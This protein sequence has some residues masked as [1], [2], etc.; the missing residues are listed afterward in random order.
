MTDNADL[1]NDHLNMSLGYKGLSARFIYDNYK[2]TNRDADLNA[3]SRSYQLDFLSAMS[4]IKYVHIWNKKLQTVFRLAHKYSEP[5][6]FKGQP[7]PADSAY[8]TYTLH[9]NTIRAN[10]GLLW[11]PFR[12]LNV[13]CGMEGYNDRG[14][15]TGDNVFRTDS[16]N[17]VSYMNYAPYAQ[18][19]FKSLF[20][21][22]TVGARY[23]I[24]TAF[25]SA[26]NPRLGITKQVGVFNFKLLYASSFRAPAIESIQYGV[27]KMKLKPERSNTLEFEASVKIRKDMYLSVNAFDINTRNAIRYFVN[28]DTVV[29][30]FPDGYRNSDKMIGS[31]GLELEYK[32]KSSFGSVNVAYSFYTVANK[33]VDESN[34]VPGNTNVT[35]GTAQN[36]CSISGTINITGKIYLSPAVIFLD[37]RYGYSSV[38]AAGQGILTSYVPQT[39]I[40]LFAGSTDLI[41]N[42]ALGIGVRNLTDEK[43]IYPQAYN[44][45]HAPLPGMGRE[46]YIR[47]NYR[48]KFKQKEN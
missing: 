47:I 9:A 28:T 48:L 46:L 41:R 21:N 24:S 22:V 12:Q 32:Y 1:N 43:I 16:T 10:V 30:G 23:D 35:L 29:V 2:T 18:V 13:S 44:S 38:D 45:L 11:D 34:A 19:L 15:L 33:T 8:S 42:V 20:A 17:K 26:F 7:E 3:L 39:L 37:K 31:Q 40:G 25:G 14:L 4:E 6:S 36:K 27:N 5:W